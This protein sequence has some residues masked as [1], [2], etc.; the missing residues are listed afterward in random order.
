LRLD[1]VV[2][3]LVAWAHTT[4]AIRLQ[5]G[6]FSWRPLIHVRDC[7]ARETLAL[8]AAPDAA[9]RGEA[10][11]IGWAANG[12]RWGAEREPSAPRP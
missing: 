10:F 5:S 3:N 1:V 12:A 7:R 11:N 8:I 9:V 6:G 4:E 2:N